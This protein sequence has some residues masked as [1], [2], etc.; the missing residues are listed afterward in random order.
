MEFTNQQL[1]NFKKYFGVQMGGRYNMFDP[2]ARAATGMTED[3]Y[4]F[5]MEHYGELEEASEKNRQEPV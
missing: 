4:V 2:R 3:E 1:Q 5:C